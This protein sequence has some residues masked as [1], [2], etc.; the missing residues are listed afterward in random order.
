MKR[1]ALILLLV[2]TSA[3]AATQKLDG[4]IPL[5]WDEDNGKLL[6]GVHSIAALA[7]RWLLSTHHVAV[8][9]EP[10]P[11][12]LDEFCFRFN[13]RRSRSRVLVFYRVLP[14]AI[15][16]DTV[17]SLPLIARSTPPPLRPS[18]PPPR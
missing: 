5:Y 2:A 12:Y 4:F 10:L 13:R 6:P 8:H 3:S 17:R 9:L 15:G 1:I 7:K 14:L 16:H 11:A 18:P